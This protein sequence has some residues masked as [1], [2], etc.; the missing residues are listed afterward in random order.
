MAR[1]L[2]SSDKDFTIQGHWCRPG[3]KHRPAGTLEVSESRFELNLLGAFD[4]A[5]GKHAFDRG[6]P[7]EDLSVIHGESAQGNPITLLN[8]F[9]TRVQPGGGLFDD[10]PVP[11]RYATLTSNGM[12]F[13]THLKHPDDQCFSS[14]CVNIPNF[15]R[16]LDDRPFNFK[17][18]LP[19]V[20]V[21]YRRPEERRFPVPSR[22]FELIFVP[23][24]VPP[25]EPWDNV[26]VRHCTRIDIRPNSPRDFD[27]FVSLVGELQ[28]FLTLLFGRT[29]QSTRISLGSDEDDDPVD[30]HLPRQRI[31]QPEMN[32]HDFL[33]RLPD[34]SPWFA[35]AVNEWFSGSHEIRHALSLLF[36]SLRSPGH[37][38]ESR[39]L[40]F[41]QAIEVYSRAIDTHTI[42]DK[43]RYKPIRK[44]LVEAIPE[45]TPEDLRDALTR[46]LGFANDRTLRERF[47]ALIGGLTP[48]SAALFCCDKAAF[49]K[50]VVNTRNHFTHYSGH[51]KAVLHGLQLHWASIK[52]QT[53]MK[54]L[55]LLRLG[56]PEANVCSI[57]GSN[58]RLVRERDAWKNVSEVGAAT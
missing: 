6:L 14:C 37:F 36:S 9:Y 15:D 10:S 30:V 42:V 49:V 33:L 28:N 29:V 34:I 44:Q 46:T 53:M 21:A 55:L 39:F 17:V 24:V 35:N 8:S 25:F 1:E 4:D 47:A 18:D 54:I 22:E 16:W 11:V 3:G 45:D 7:V 41:V 12:L 19:D 48:E 27:W 43:E 31:S 32:P 50:G 23:T 52:L 51:S 38:L 5:E 20:A 40:P 2:Y 13:G 58:Y 57:V 56:I 26:E